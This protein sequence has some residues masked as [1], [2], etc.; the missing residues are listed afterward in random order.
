MHRHQHGYRHEH[1]GDDRRH[2]RGG[3]GFGGQHRHRGLHGGRTRRVFDQGDLRYVLLQLIADKPSH[4]YELIKA[5]DERSNGYYVPSPGMV[6]PA[7]TYLEEIGHASVEVEG[8]KKRYTISEAGLD[9]L[10]KNRAAVDALLEQL[11]W[12]GKRMNDV[13]EAM[14]GAPP[15]D[16]DFDD[17]SS[18]RGRGRHAAGTPEVR[19]A[20]RNLKSALIEKSGA[21][22]A[23]Q[24]RIAAILERAAAEIR[25]DGKVD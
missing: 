15:S 16:G 24:K 9:H 5:L 8:T 17:P 4:G 6:Y 3:F 20:R 2:M 14:H 18:F 12:I 11:A 10:E 19:Q 13:R 1:Q 25:A 22:L 7:L 23:E 21:T